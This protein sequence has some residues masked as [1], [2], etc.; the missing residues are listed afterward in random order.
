V[1]LRRIRISRLPGIDDPFTVDGF[2]DGI[3][4][5]VG[6]NGIGKSSLCRAMRQL[7][8]PKES[9]RQFTSASALFEDE[10]GQWTVQA[11]SQLPR[12][13]LDG[14]DTEPPPAPAPHLD[15]CFFLRL[16]DLIES[17]QN[18]G[19]DV[20]SEIRRQMA[21][22]FDLSAVGSQFS[23]KIGNR[24]GRS[25]RGKFHDVQTKINT[26]K[27][28]Q[29]DLSRQQSRLNA[30]AQEIEAVDSAQRRLPHVEAAI[31]LNAHK[32]DLAAIEE[33]LESMPSVLEGLSG[34]ESEDV[35]LIDSQLEDK[36]S[37][38]RTAERDLNQ[39]NTDTE[40]TGL[41]EQIPESEL[42]TGNSYAES[43]SDLDRDLNLAMR[44]QEGKKR[45]LKQSRQT[46]G[47]HADVPEN[48]DLPEASKL[49]VFLRE[50]NSASTRLNAIDEQIGILDKA[51]PLEHD[52]N[53]SELLDRGIRS[54]R[55]WLSTPIVADFQQEHAISPSRKWMFVA[56]GILIAAGAALGG[57]VHTAFLAIAGAGV[58]LGVSGWLVRVV[59]SSHTDDGD[60]RKVHQREFPLDLEVPDSWSV[61]SVTA[62]LREFER[63]MAASVA[64][65]GQ[66]AYRD[67]DRTRLDVER[68]KVVKGIDELDRR[69]ATLA[70][71]LELDAI[72][73]DAELVDMAR[74]VD[75]LRIALQDA[76]DAAGEIDEIERQQTK[77]LDKLS[78]ILAKYG[79][80]APTDSA[81]AKAAVDALVARNQDLL[82][83]KAAKQNADDRLDELK[84][85]IEAL[86]RRKSEIYG[87]AN[88]E[89]DDRL[90]LETLIESIGLY[91]ENKGLESGLIT[92]VLTLERTFR[93]AGADDLLEL[94]HTQLEMKLALLKKE[95][96][97]GQE[98]RSEE[99][100]IKSEI[101]KAKASN[102]LEALI[103][104][105]EEARETLRTRQ[106]EVLL[107]AAGKF[108]VAKVEKE[109][110]LNQMPKVLERAQDLFR[111][112]T[113]HSYELKVL[114]GDQGSFSA[115]DTITHIG[116]KP[117]ELSDGTRAQLLLA[118][119]LAFADK[120][121]Q[122]VRL[123]LF[124]DEALDQSDPARYEAIVQSLARISAKDD[125]QIIYLTNDPTDITRI[126][127]ALAREDYDAANVIDLAKVR[128][129]D[130][131]ITAPEGLTVEP[132]PPIPD[133]EGMTPEQYGAELTIP[134]FDPARGHRAQHLLYLL[135]DDL[136]TLHT[137]LQARIDRVGKWLALSAASAPVA[138]EIAAG[139][140]VGREL[141]HRAQLLEAFCE[142][143]SDGRGRAV[144]GEVIE[145]SRAVSSRFLRDVSDICRELN[146]DGER[147]IRALRARKDPR[148]KGFKNSSTDSLENYL[149]ENGHIDT[150][151]VLGESDVLTRVLTSPAATRLA[152]DLTGNLVHRWFDLAENETSDQ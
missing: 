134:P 44:S 2:S 56:G 126:Q 106:S 150:R 38:Q 128:N 137:L 86:E 138:N 98:L 111:D 127:G 19:N 74:A 3:T 108:L 85:E 7:I 20:A 24:P 88:I 52:S 82:K 143:F 101:R 66:I 61:E 120:A 62:R 87:R 121:E 139:D 54:L 133:P 110:E 11:D 40:A 80:D 29:E 71:E 93:S 9:S 14:V 119:R 50:C 36:A 123:P 68:E 34:K 89:V 13:Q 124:L 4:L 148:L 96:D 25:E 67:A 117:D 99:S 64:A 114:Q 100:D 17:T 95:V 81:T 28:K 27:L 58:G 115:V 15:Q 103:A 22:G 151:P 122:G 147:L 125:R 6:P 77:L 90:G 46:C 79:V 70:R 31:G 116:R 59:T 132:L 57:L 33:T 140:G 113:H 144:N 43:L 146:A 72:P 130:G 48:L 41:S 30:L 39:A 12:W 75:Q 97:G 32:D 73:P 37:H 149:I 145:A 118:S 49:F 18:A 42:A 92:T 8:W 135:W 69:R 76:K 107:G 91:K 105:R 84:T 83:A 23:S 65:S 10:R 152:G 104:E 142:A 55:A 5:I 102:D 63:D 47:G 131:G 60:A 129:E 141:D 112:F 35:E 45:V 1:K 26:A 53:R 109:Y 21:G 51:T 94:D 136:E 16:P 78:P